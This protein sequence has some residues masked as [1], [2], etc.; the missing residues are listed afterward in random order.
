MLF[1]GQVLDKKQ[2][3]AKMTKAIT[4]SILIFKDHYIEM[5]CTKFQL[6]IMFSFPG[7]KINIIL[8]YGRFCKKLGSKSGNMDFS[9][10]K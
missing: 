10:V 6:S 7:K 9:A 4:L 8:R 1:F 2:N 5:I 3:S